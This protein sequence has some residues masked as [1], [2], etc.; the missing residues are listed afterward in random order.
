M[1]LQQALNLGKLQNKWEGPFMVAQASTHG[2]YCLAELD[3][4]P[5]PH[6]WNAEALK[7]YYMP[8]GPA[9][10]RSRAWLKPR[11]PGSPCEGWR[12]GP[13]ADESYPSTREEQTVEAPASDSNGLNSRHGGSMAAA[14]PVQPVD[15]ATWP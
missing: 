14:F 4:A 12:S 9:P 11:G 3:G 15:G 5:L 8:L 7:K 2:A 1:V 6:P 10:R 13:R